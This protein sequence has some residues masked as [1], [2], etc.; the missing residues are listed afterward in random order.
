MKTLE[1]RAE[2]QALRWF[3]GN[4]PHAV[5]LQDVL[6]P[7]FDDARREAVAT[8]YSCMLKLATR[9]ARRISIPR[10]SSFVNNEL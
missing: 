3:R 7:F 6:K 2:H 5:R 1:E 8:E 9:E 4:E 10:K